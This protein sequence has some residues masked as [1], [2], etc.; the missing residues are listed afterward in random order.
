MVWGFSYWNEANLLAFLFQGGG[1]YTYHPY[2][3]DVPYPTTGAENP[4][5][6]I[7]PGCPDYGD[8]YNAVYNYLHIEGF[9]KMKQPD[10][11]LNI[12]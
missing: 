2:L 5:D 8:A 12:C 3:H 4:A 1:F 11:G 7:L 9:A 6:Y 10:N